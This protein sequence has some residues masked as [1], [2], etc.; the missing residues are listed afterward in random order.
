MLIVA[1]GQVFV[2]RPAR[3]QA[4]ERFA[5]LVGNDLGGAGTQA[6]LYARQDA[7]RIRD[8]LIRVGNVKEENVISLLGED[9]SAVRRA[10]DTLETRVKAAGARGA[11][12][13][14]IVYYSGHAKDGDLRLG[15]SR[16]AMDELRARVTRSQA[17]LK[18]AIIDACQ[19]GALTR[20][21]GAR[22]ATA[23]EIESTSGAQASGTVMLTS[24][25]FDEDAQESDHIGGSYFSHHFV[26]GLQGAADRSGDGKVTLAEA[27]AHAYSR[28]VASTAESAAGP[29]H[30]TFSYD[31]KGNGDF[32]LS[33]YARRREG[34]RLPAAAP[35]GT[36]FLVD[37]TGVVAAE[38]DKADNQERRVS[39][40]PGIYKVKR[41]LPDRLRVGEVRVTPG[42]LAVLDESR[43]VDTPFS[44]DPVKGVS[45]DLPGQWALTVGA[46]S[47]AFFDEPT[48][49]SLFPSSG[50]LAAELS[51]SNFLRPGW[52]LGFD[53]AMGGGQGVVAQASGALGFETRQFNLGASIWADWPWLDGDLTPFFGARVAFLFLDRRF[54][55]D[56]LPAQFFSTFSP[57]L[58]GGMRYRLNRRLQLLGRA[59]L[60]YLLY[61]VDVNRSLGFAE[62]TLALGYDF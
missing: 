60:H 11:R 18:L 9:A 32:V 35:A 31:L 61:N 43:L 39:I 21:K 37:T 55:E 56:A 62:L 16:L 30:P 12:T 42:E 13:T 29:Q 7:R 10:L 33:D 8:V 27:Y 34:L 53:M 52:V 23:F 40:A 59:R 51:V 36:Y 28:T 6:L 44:D 38:I 17:T 3:G 47:Q 4:E 19:S 57:G 50:L 20:T 58:V 15:S 46:T 1:A 24:S 49:E 5:L 54:E 25:S 22:K 41:R 2:A 14:L 45:R 48:R 26:S